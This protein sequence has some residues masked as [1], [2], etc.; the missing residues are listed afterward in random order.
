MEVKTYKLMLNTTL[1][2]RER[3]RSSIELILC[4]CFIE[5]IFLFFQYNDKYTI[6]KEST[7]SKTPL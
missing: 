5:I 1:N 7:S 4:F 3:E 2:E 6:T